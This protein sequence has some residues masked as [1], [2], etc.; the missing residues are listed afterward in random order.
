MPIA[1][2]QLLSDWK[3]IEL[4]Q[5]E[6][7]AQLESA[8]TEAGTACSADKLLEQLVQ[9][10]RLT[11]FQAQ[12]CQAGRARE[13]RLGN[14]LLIEKLGEGGMGAVYQ[15]VHTRLRR[16]VALKTISAK[17]I[18]RGLLERFHREVL[19]IGQLDHPHV[20]RA[21]HASEDRGVSYLVME[22]VAGENL[23]QV[24]QRHGRL[25]VAD[26]CEAV[27]QAAEGLEYIHRRGLVHR[28]LKPSNLMLTPEGQVK[29]LDLG[30]AVL[31]AGEAQA[32]RLTADGE[33]VGTIDYMAP[34]QAIGSRDVDIRADL[35]SLGC[36]LYRLLTGQPVF[37]GPQYPGKVQR[38][39]GHL[40]DPAPPIASL[41]PDLPP[42]LA[43]LIDRLL[44]KSPAERLQIPSELVAALLPFAV[45]ANLPRLL[46]EGSPAAGTAAT[47][48]LPPQPRLTLA[49][50][51][52]RPRRWTAAALVPLATCAI[53]GIAA[54]TYAYRVL[55][56]NALPPSPLLPP[57]AENKPAEKSSEE[58]STLGKAHL[59]KREYQQAIVC[60]DQAI[61]LDPA[62][63]LAYRRRGACYA[64]LKEWERAIGDYTEGIRLNPTA[65]A[66]Y[67]N[68]GR[69]HHALQEFDLAVA[70][71]SEA[72]RLAPTESL[73]HS[74]RGEAHLEQQRYEA[75]IADFNVAIQLDSTRSRTFLLRGVAYARQQA[76]DLA[77]ADYSEA[78]RLDP[79]NATAYSN[80]GFNYATKKMWEQAIAD[81]SA[82]IKLQ[83]QEPSYLV[84]RG[85]MYRMQGQHDAAL[86]DF[87]AALGMQPHSVAAL[88]QRG[89]TYHAQGKFD[90][91]IADQTEI[92]RLD[93]NSTVA[94]NNRGYARQ[95]KEEYD[96]ALVDYDE[97]LRREPTNT[98]TLRNRAD[99]HYDRKD[100]AKSISDYD[101]VIRLDPGSPGALNN[102]GLAH[103]MRN[104]ILLAIADY[105]A[106]I[107]RNSQDA[108]PFY[109]RGNAFLDQKDYG[110]AI[111]D[112]DNA[113]LLNPDR[114]DYYVRRGTAH[115]NHKAADLAI[116]DFTEAIRLD[117]K[118]SRAFWLRGV[119]HGN[120]REHELAVADFSEAIRLDPND[121]EQ[122]EHR[123]RSHNALGRFDLALADFDAAVRTDPRNVSAL[124][125]RAWLRATCP[126]ATFRDGEQ[127]VADATQAC[128]LQEWK[129]AAYL[130][131]LAAAYAEMGDFA[132]AIEWQTK[133]LE[134]DLPENKSRHQ[135]RL[136]LFRTQ[137][138]YRTDKP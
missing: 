27:R 94:M 43:A 62:N 51:Q 121:A 77:I 9:D 92:L 111:A 73:H 56:R 79:Q 106:A 135:Q 7:L 74:S 44:A 76:I 24:V 55:P 45:G 31:R 91:S 1:L 113:I 70:D 116:S 95:A 15:A 132:K 105:S 137:Q 61:R 118:N 52:A 10:R 83:P 53:V 49:E 57:I 117:A 134:R 129:D 37:C 50:P 2:D 108:L 130:D 38:L 35:Y 59:D 93:P 69:A 72:I 32:D 127:A 16:T 47:V 42:P 25:T 107:R 33:A 110:Q 115:L 122:Y 4:F 86:T 17:A 101:E 112:Y 80:R 3:E 128:A 124:N 100:Y 104:E 109:N 75:A 60:F 71:F 66:P 64:G 125:S 26:A 6:E 126:D 96:L 67:S 138:P 28:D 8:V 58:H 84:S 21:A 29:I 30:L 11:A 20:V 85:Q 120:K 81:F 40:R 13:L 14:Y 5:P 48:E 22:Y 102:R 68:R 88:H 23:A 41:R 89:L 46:A 54:A 87:N 114:S 99:V 36:T 65:A 12:R 131:T 136:E 39:M 133:A 78:I 82:A 19:A 90:L 34:E 97:V 63:G 18:D 123:G 103:A 119:S 98:W